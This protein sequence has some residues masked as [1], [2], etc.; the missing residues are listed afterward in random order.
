M[1]GYSNTLTICPY[2]GTGCGLYLQ[3]LDGRAVGV[4]PAK[5]HPISEGMLCIKGWNCISFV[6]HPDRLSQPLIR[7][8][9]QLEAA[10]W[11]QALDRVVGKFNEVLQES[12]P[13][14]IGFLCS[15]KC[16]SEE[17]YL[18]QKLARSVIGTP[19]IDHCARL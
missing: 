5:Q 19:H 17:N 15:A 2:C 8:A 6:Y 1:M 10:S 12:G 16:T 7:R 11:D 13:D 3:V 9:G 4:L 18:L 14:A